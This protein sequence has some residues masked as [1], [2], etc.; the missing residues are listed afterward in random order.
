MNNIC[1]NKQENNDNLVNNN[2]CENKQENNDVNVEEILHDLT[3][4]KDKFI[5][6][7]ADFENYKKRIQKEKIKLLKLANKDLLIALLPIMD[8]FE[9]GETEVKKSQGI[10]LIRDKL[11][12]ILEFHGLEK[13]K[14]N[15][16]DDFN[17]DL[18]EAVTQITTSSKDLNGKVVKV[19]EAGYT[20][21]GQ[22]IR[23]AK[24][25]IGKK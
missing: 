1:E 4:Q 10:M 17:T 20:L 6:L 8:D 19:L 16:G 5:R 18:H 25:V 15:S 14:I 7:F 9:R 24:V 23:H 22:I 21:K 13:I 3:I 12:K 11:K 2:I